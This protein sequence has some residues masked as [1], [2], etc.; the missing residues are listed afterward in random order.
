MGGL[1]R[2]YSGHKYRYDCAMTTAQAETLGPRTA[3]RWRVCALLLMST[4]IV[5]LNRTTMGVLKVRLETNLHFGEAE[6]GWLQ[7]SFQT[8]YAVMFVAAGRFVDKVG[9]KI[10]LAVGVIFWSLATIAGGF[11]RT[12]QQLA[13][14]QFFLGCGASVNFP[15]SF[16][17]V[18]EWF[19]QKE[20]ALSAGIFNSGSN[21]GIMASVFAAW[22]AV[23]FGWPWAFYIVGATGFL[24]IVPWLWGY[25][26]VE[27]HKKVSPA[28]VAY[29]R[30]GQPLAVKHRLPWTTL[31]RYR[32]T[33]PFVI[34]KF[35]TDP[36]WWFYSGWLPGY[37]H[38]TRG[39]SLVGSA[40]WLS[41]PYIA[42]DIGSI[43]GGWISGGLMHRGW[44]V[45]PARYAAMGLCALGMPG[46]IIAVHAHNFWLAIGLI[47]LATASHQGW[48]ANLFTTATD[49]FPTSL[50]G[51]MV[52]LGGMTGAVGGML[53][54]L[55]VGGTLAR[56]G[57]YTP[58]FVWA[59]LMH[60]LAWVLF[61]LIAGP[62]MA[63]VEIIPGIDKYFSARLAVAGAAMIGIGAVGMQLVWTYWNWLRDPRTL[64]PSVPAGG[65]VAAAAIALIGIALIYAS[66]PR[67]AKEMA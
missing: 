48:S 59:G 56:L 17:A 34:A 53:M 12:W 20:R 51:S 47:S 55:L 54:T 33:W 25:N 42:A 32:Q 43:F 38:D 44:R 67:A 21:L 3:I 64:S 8:A 30:A 41:V 7:F 14:A 13:A 15:A 22:A 60:P 1:T 35:L 65:L 37:L 39:L 10:S 49:L 18:A 11:C 57:D 4:T 31:L 50:A 29:I 63:K 45:G 66:L 27:K 23:H 28:E 9:A 46:A 5:Y 6:Y 58:A 2:I 16:K 24:W 26:S 40:G 61:F 52:G 62:K 19:P 36:V